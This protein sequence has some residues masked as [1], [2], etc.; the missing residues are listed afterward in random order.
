MDVDDCFNEDEVENLQ[1]NDEDE[2][3]D[4]D[5]RIEEKK[6]KPSKPKSSARTT[7]D[8]K[9]TAKATI[10]QSKISDDD[11]DFEIMDVTPTSRQTSTLK[12][13]TIKE[14]K[15]NTL[16]FTSSIP[17]PG[18]SLSEFKNPEMSKQNDSQ[19]PISSAANRRMPSS[20]SQSMNSNSSQKK[21]SNWD[22]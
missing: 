5:F 11:D 20:F 12:N 4:D 14:K 9:S 21:K 17:K 19:I 22:D 1:Y 2:F 6:S 18:V 10:I 3:I 15:M 7:K 13:N 8:K 16:P